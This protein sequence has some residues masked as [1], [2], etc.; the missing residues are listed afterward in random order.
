MKTL[1]RGILSLIIG[2][3]L[4]VTSFSSCTTNEVYD[5]NFELPGQIVTEFGQTITVPF[6]ARNITSVVLSSSP[7]G[8][9]VEKIDLD[10]WTITITAPSEFASD[11]NNIEENGTLSLTGYTAASTP[12]H[13]TSYLS[14]LNKSADLTSIYSNSYIITEHDTRYTIDVSH[15]G[16]SAETISPANVGVLWQSEIGLISHCSFFAESNTF[17]F[18]IGSERVTDDEG[19]EIGRC[20]TDGNAVVA[21]YDE[22][23]VIL[24]SWH[25][26]LTGSDPTTNAI[27]TSVGTFMDRNLGAYHNSDGSV[28][29]GD[30]FK[31]F[32]LYYQWGRKDPFVRPTDYNFSSNRDQ[33]VYDYI[34]D[35]QSFRYV[36]ATT[37]GVG[38]YDYAVAHPMSFVK[39]SAD[40]GYDWLYSAHDNTLWSADAKSINDP[41]PRGW[42]M[43]AG[44][45]FTAFDISEEEDAAPSAD[46]KNMYGWHLVDV[47]TGVKMFMPAAGRRS[48]ETGRLT[49]INNYGYEHNPM[50][51]TGYYWTAGVGTDDATSMF[52]DLNTTRAVNNRYE[53]TKQMH[54]ANAMQ[55]RCVRE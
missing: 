45:V 29:Q 46:V 13:A 27:T 5:F 23:G 6:R 51:W 53:P 26:W 19:N 7:K 28:K 37:E 30:I 49:N 17:S 1:F 50:P 42:R 36:D 25:L 38:T 54:R 16:E 21:A 32:G 48:F 18:Y 9:K 10:N 33:S 3:A 34:G 22:N 12:I 40:N 4:C 31:S 20:I 11:G 44:D 8:W 43:P 15:K 41:C 14:L 47:A 39:G 24:W 55:V 2:V 35:Y 52:F